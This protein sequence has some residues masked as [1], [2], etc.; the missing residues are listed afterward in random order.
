M[1]N[2]QFNKYSEVALTVTQRE[3]KTK[4]DI[5]K[6]GSYATRNGDQIEVIGHLKGDCVKTFIQIYAPWSKDNANICWKLESYTICKS[7]IV[8]NYVFRTDKK[9]VMEWFIDCNVKY[10]FD[11]TRDTTI[12]DPNAYSIDLSDND[13]YIVYYQG[14]Q[15]AKVSR[16]NDLEQVIEHFKIE[17]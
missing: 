5:M 7:G 14:K 9:D 16:L 2:I 10:A 1:S 13:Y 11:E 3:L 15:F 17:G 12:G 8:W 6:S 4:F